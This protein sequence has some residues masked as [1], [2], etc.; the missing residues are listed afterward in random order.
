MGI[1]S[2][3]IKIRYGIGEKRK[4]SEYPIDNEVSVRADRETER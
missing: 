4:K 1:Q 3:A 2:K